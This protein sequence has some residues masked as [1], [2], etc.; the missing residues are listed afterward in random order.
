[1]L[2]REMDH[3]VKNLFTLANSV[4][5]L[6]ARSATTAEELVSGVGSRLK[7]LAQAHALTIAATTD[8]GSR[9]EQETTLHTLVRTIIAPYDGRVE[10]QPTRVNLSGPDVTISGSVV[11][12]FALLLHEF[13]TNAAKYGSLSTM[14]G[15]VE[16]TCMHDADMFVLTWSESGGPSVAQTEDGDGFGT[17]LGRATVRSQ[18]GGEISREWKREGL[19]IRLAVLF[20]RLTGRY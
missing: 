14:D 10:H 15:C 8:A 6:S 13:A 9:T 7:A 16:I 18:L 3:R 12:S 2:I 11:T 17:L 5:S 19:V 20:S 4:V 1:M